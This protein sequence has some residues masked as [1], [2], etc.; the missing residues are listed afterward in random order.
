M[1]SRLGART[2]TRFFGPGGETLGLQIYTL[3]ADALKDLDQAFLDIAQIGYR[4]VELLSFGDQNVDSMRH[5]LK[6]SGLVATGTQTAF[7]GP[8]PNLTDHIGRLIDEAHLL[9]LKYVATT[10]FDI[11]ARMSAHGPNDVGGSFVRA[12]LAMTADDWKSYGDKL[13][14]VGATLKEH[15]LRIAHHN[16]NL[17][18]VKVG[19]VTGLDLVVTHTDPHLVSFEIDVGWVAA[20][21]HDPIELLRRYPGRFH[22]MHMKDIKPSTVPNNEFKQVPAV[23]GTGVL[24]WPRLLR[25]AKVA[26]VNAYYVEQEG[27][28]E[29][30]RMDAVRRNYRYLSSLVA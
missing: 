11:P 14:R 17:E 19:E 24:D 28:F 10:L 29:T 26:G 22:M 7:Q 20:A 9:G 30:T 8:G 27:P 21:G 5:A 15:G 6:R 18:F 13:S 1:T 16:H 12:A 2:P 3:G 4:S 25:T 23:P